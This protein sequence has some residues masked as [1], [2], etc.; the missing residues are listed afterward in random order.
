MRRAFSRP[1]GG[2]R[3][4]A[5][6]WTAVA[7]AVLMVVVG[8]VFW[9]GAAAVVRHRAANTADLAALAAAA[10]ADRGAG[11]ACAKARWV[12]ERMG[13]EPR[14]CRLEGL[15][16]FVRVALV[17]EGFLGR[18][19]VARARARAGPVDTALIDSGGSAGAMSGTSG[20]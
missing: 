17:P 16:A 4:V 6:V 5:S 2:D 3:G 15:D 19:G 8:T 11:V 14:G 18:F 9:L 20:G 12:I 10:Y 7:V 1:V 13:A